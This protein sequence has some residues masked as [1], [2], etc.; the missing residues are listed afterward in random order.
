MKRHPDSLGA[1]LLAS[2]AVT[3]PHKRPKPVTLSP[4]QRAWR[5]VRVYLAGRRKPL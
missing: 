1:M 2:G 5:A 4:L 3:G